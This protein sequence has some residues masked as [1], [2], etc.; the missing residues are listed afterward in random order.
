LNHFEPDDIVIVMA[1]VS[2]LLVRLADRAAAR[3]YAAKADAARL[4]EISLS[5]LTAARPLRERVAQIEA[6]GGQRGVFTIG[7]ELPRL[8]FSP[9]LYLLETSQSIERLAFRWQELELAWGIPHRTVFRSHGHS[10]LHVDCLPHRGAPPPVR[11]NLMICGA[12][13]RLLQGQGYAGLLV[14]AHD[15]ETGWVDIAHDNDWLING[16]SI[17]EH[18][19]TFRIAWAAEPPSWSARLFLHNGDPVEAPR[20]IRDVIAAIDLARLAP[21]SPSRLASCTNVSLRTLHR[22][23]RAHGISAGALCRKARLRSA[24]QEIAN[25]S[26]RL[27]DIAYE[28][29]FSDSAHLSREFGKASGMTPRLYRRTAMS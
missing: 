7:E 11:Q 3:P 28:C 24:C 4:V 17:T 10:A 13:A 15:P 27:T 18:T 8:P 9:A 1:Q 12:L 14:S 25:T 21:W 26:R 19:T 22:R 6:V 5:A 23:L 29:G 20:F 16:S 2:T